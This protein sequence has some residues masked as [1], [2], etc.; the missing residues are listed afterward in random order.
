MTMMKMHKRK[1]LVVFFFSFVVDS[2]VFSLQV[3][4]EVF[5]TDMKSSL[6]MKSAFQFEKDND[7]STSTY[8]ETTSRNKKN[9]LSSSLA[10]IDNVLIN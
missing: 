4:A 8:D 2:I 9:R 6:D 7:G 10:R 1:R 5:S 3:H